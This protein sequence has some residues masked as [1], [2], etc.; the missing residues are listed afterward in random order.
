MSSFLTSLAMGVVCVSAAPLTVSAA[1]SDTGLKV[2]GLQASVTGTVS[3]VEAEQRTVTLKGPQG[4][5]RTFG[6]DDSVALDRVK[7]GDLIRLDYQRAVAVA[8]RKG[9]DGIREQVE[10]EAEARTQ[11]DGKPGLQA[12][13]R[14]TVVTNVLAVDQH[15]QTV[16]LQGPQGRVADFRVKDK[17]TL[18]DVK[19]G[20]QVVAV[21]HE[22]VA[23][24]MKAATQR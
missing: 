14:T 21:V 1:P 24:R 19:V 17:A 22:A 16:R 3:A 5:E 23:V 12:N 8:L 15:E 13:K 11:Q 9:G 10:A 20:D 6:V 18:A 4:Q 7:V 2:V